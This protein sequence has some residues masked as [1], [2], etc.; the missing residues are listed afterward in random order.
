VYHQVSF[1]WRSP[2]EA[3][4]HERSKPIARPNAAKTSGSPFDNTTYIGIQYC[5]VAEVASDLCSGRQC[6]PFGMA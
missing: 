3:G 2:Q 1:V 6:L 5:P 4:M